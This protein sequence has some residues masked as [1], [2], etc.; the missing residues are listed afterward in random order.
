MEYPWKLH[1][2][3][4]AGPLFCIDR[5]N[6]RMWII[7][8][9]IIMKVFGIGI[10][11]I[12]VKMVQ[13]FKLLRIRL[14]IIVMCKRLRKIERYCCRHRLMHSHIN[15]NV[16]NFVTSKATTWSHLSKH[17]LLQKSSQLFP[18]KIIHHWWEHEASN[19]DIVYS[20]NTTECGKRYETYA[21]LYVKIKG[22]IILP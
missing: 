6:V 3:T 4:V 16:Q 8:I 7:F 14:R 9:S 2:F 1:N 15:I 12:C 19:R 21:L 13:T 22:R 11:F 17:V 5:P 18:L 10:I 20:F